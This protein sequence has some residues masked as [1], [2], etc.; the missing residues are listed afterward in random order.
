MLSGALRCALKFSA[1]YSCG[2]IAATMDSVI[3]SWTAKTPA[4]SRSYR[5]AQIDMATSRDVVELRR[6]AHAFAILPHAALDDISNAE[7]AC[8]LV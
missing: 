6:D 8:D 3:S 2:S 5:S 1:A 7:F 4:K